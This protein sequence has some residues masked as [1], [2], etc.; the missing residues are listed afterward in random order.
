MGLTGNKM[1]VFVPSS[2]QWSNKIHLLR[3]RLFPKGDVWGQICLV[4]HRV[5]LSFFVVPS[6]SRAESHLWRHS[7]VKNLEHIIPTRSYVPF[8]Q[9]LVIFA[10][11]G[12]FDRSLLPFWCELSKKQLFIK[13]IHYF[14]IIDNFIYVN[15]KASQ[16]Y[17]IISFT[18]NLIFQTHFPTLINRMMNGAHPFAVR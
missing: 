18:D 8:K 16:P 1:F 11:S 4:G 6:L 15:N 13:P 5:T 14:S 3:S 9:Q 7:N 12:G 10:F 2:F 17:S